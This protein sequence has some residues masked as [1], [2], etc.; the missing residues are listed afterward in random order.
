MQRFGVA[1]M[2]LL[3]GGGMLMTGQ[4]TTKERWQPG[5]LSLATL[6]SP[7]R[8]AEEGDRAVRLLWREKP[9]WQYNYGVAAPPGAPPI[10]ATSGFLHPV[11]SLAGAIVT[12]WGPPDHFH[13]RGIFFAWAKTRWGDLQPDFWN[14]HANTG[15]TRFDAFERLELYPDRAVMVVRHLWEAHRDGAWLPVV[16]ERWTLTTFA[17]PSADASFWLFDLTTELVNTTEMPLV[18]EE[19][20]YGGLGCRGNGVWLD[21]ARYEVLNANGNDRT[22]ADNVPTR[23][24]LMGGRVDGQWAGITQMDHPRNLHFPNAPRL[25]PNVPFVGFAPPRKGAF[26]MQPHQPLVFHYR[27]V[28][29]SVKPTPQQLDALWEQFAK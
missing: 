20:R 5:Q 25:T 10:H 27:F 8:F 6:G 2:T 16:R 15:R 23:W 9:L 19:Y 22:T 29:H 4:P 3:T 1:V 13:H 24:V 18:V 26:T 21:A 17:P 12:D 7:F 14:L 28:V 11:W